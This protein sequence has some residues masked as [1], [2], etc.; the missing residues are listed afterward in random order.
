MNHKKCVLFDVDGT[1]VDTE[2]VTIKALNITIKKLYNKEYDKSELEFAIGLPGKH[3]L[4]KLGVKNTEVTLQDWNKEIRKFINEV[5]LFPQIEETLCFFKNKNIKLG[6]VTSRYD[7]EVN[8]DIIL[9]K[10]LHYFDVIVAYS[11][12]LRP[13]PYPDQLLK[14]LNELNIDPYDALYVGDTLYDYECAKSGNVD[15]ILANWGKV[16]RRDNFNDKNI[17]ICK[18]PIELLE[19]IIGG[20]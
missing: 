4:D 10:V 3:A 8:E 18:K 17:K 1:L 11:E 20:R 12:V 14:A 15:F 13:K 9:N 19:Q 6:I 5:K 2:E 16:D 7:F